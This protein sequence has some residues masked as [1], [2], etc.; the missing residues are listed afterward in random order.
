MKI[1]P[2]IIAIFITFLS[3][4]QLSISTGYRAN[5][6]FKKFVSSNIHL[7]L[8]Y[9]IN[10]IAFSF[11]TSYLYKRNIKNEINTIRSISGGG[12]NPIVE[13]KYYASSIGNFNY[14][15]MNIGL[16]RLFEGESIFIE[17]I[18]T[19]TLVGLF[20][21][22]DVLLAYKEKDFYQHSIITRAPSIYDP[23]PHPVEILSDVTTN[24]SIN[25]FCLSIGTY[26]LEKGNLLCNVTPG[27]DTGNLVKS[28]PA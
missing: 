1:S 22:M 25:N 2:L 8:S 28:V 7:D 26:L 4:A 18:N 27:S 9:K 13:Q 3:N 11:E 5:V 6:E 24:N 23:N 14:L 16:H 19:T 20:C 15:A 21:K 10:K 12:F 17:G